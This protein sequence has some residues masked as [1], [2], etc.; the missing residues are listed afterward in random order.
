MAKKLIK[1]IL[2]NKSNN[3]KIEYEFK[4]IVLDNKITYK[5]NDMLVNIQL[6]KDI[7]LTRSDDIKRITLNFKLNEKTKCTYEIYGKVLELNLCTNKIVR[8]ENYLEIDYKI[9]E[10]NINFKLYIK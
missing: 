9:E 4:G 2:E 10:E 7:I 1:S 5:E 8:E 3:E 6:N